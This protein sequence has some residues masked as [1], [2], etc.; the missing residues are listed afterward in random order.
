MAT[1]IIKSNASQATN[2]QIR[3]V[4]Y[5]IL[6]SG[7]SETLDTPE[8][9][10]EAQQS[11]YLRAFLVDDAYGVGSS[12]LI[13]NDGLA[14]IAQS[15]AL[16]FLDTVILPQGDE[17]Y[18]V[19]KTNASGQIDDDINWDGTATISNVVLGNDLNTA[20]NE[21][22]GLPS[23]PSGP[24]ASTS[25]EYVDQLFVQNR[26]WK[27][28]LLQKEQLIDGAAGGV[29][30]AI[31][32]YL[33]NQP[34]N[35]DTLSVTDGVLT[36]T[37]GFGS[38]GDVVVTIG[39]NVDDTMSN[40][41]ATITGDGSSL[42][43]AAKVT[44]LNSINGGGGSSTSGHLVV[45]YRESQS[46][47]SF[48]DR[49]F[50]TFTT[51]P[52][53]QYVNYF[54]EKDY[55]SSLS[56]QLPTI[57]PAQKE[58][59]IGRAFA[60][61]LANETHRVRSE[62]LGYT[63]DSDGEAWQLTDGSSIDYGLVSD[64]QPLGSSLGAGVSNRVARAD[65]VHTHGDRGGDGA[66]SQHDADQVD[67]EGTYPI[68]SPSGPVSAEVA[69]QNIG[70]GFVDPAKV[71][72]SLMTQCPS[73]VRNGVPSQAMF[74]GR[75]SMAATPYQF[76][77]GGTLKGVRVVVD[78]V[79]ASRDYVVSIRVGATVAAVNN[80]ANEVETLALPSGSS[81]AKSLALSAVVTA[82]QYMAVYLTRTSGTGN[83]TFGNM[84]I[85]VEWVE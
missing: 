31:P 24:T 53:A 36:R 81:T 48:D 82:D 54:G 62:D 44:D 39:A 63:W 19:V 7:G 47:D 59:G 14:D 46:A 45:I 17:D 11:D 9:I 71:G 57:D 27:E 73:R 52:D 23:V 6:A 85:Q 60:S 70:A 29:S 10:M 33:A 34:S 38:G 42:W 18:G 50:G 76:L 1:L 61:L 66:G 26:A 58:F 12:T 74:I 83:S 79:D 28:V 30:Q 69:F 43:D 40:L 25:K 41:A 72:K 51:Q 16:N 49:I 68:V 77:R 32:L 78:A 22:I 67:V 75:V 64:I 55:Q 56:A 4:G 21:V 5:S 84:W 35:G 8:E 2:V 3:D 20:G 65:H 13:L 80:V 15:D 37:Y